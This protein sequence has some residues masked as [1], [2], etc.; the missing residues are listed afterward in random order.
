MEL[1]RSNAASAVPS[2][3]AYTRKGKCQSEVLQLK[4]QQKG[5]QP[6]WEISQMNFMMNTMQQPAPHAM[7]M[8]QTHMKKNAPIVYWKNCVL[9]MCEDFPCCGHEMNDCDG[10]L[11]G[12]DN[13]IKQDMWRMMSRM[14]DA[15]MGDL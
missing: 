4:Y 11:Y 1:R 9:F 10:S 2:K 15:E 8:P 7:K 12:S 13:A 14:A 6:L 5:E 3:K